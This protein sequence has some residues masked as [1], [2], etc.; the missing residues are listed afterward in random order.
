[1]FSSIEDLFLNITIGIGLI[2]GIILLFFVIKCIINI[3][4]K[5]AFEDE[6]NIKLETGFKVRENKNKYSVNRFELCYPKWTYSNK[7]GSKNKVRNNNSLI[8]YYSTLYFERF[9]LRTKSPIQMIDLVKEIRDK[10][11]DNII[12][13]SPE[14]IKKYTELKRKKDLINKA[15]VAQTIIDS[16]AEDPTDFETFCAELLR[17]MGYEAEVTQK[18]NDGGY[19]IILNKDF[20]KSI[21]ECKCYAQDHSIGRPMIQKLV[22]ANHEAKANNM[23]F[24]TT[25]KFS[26][27]A[28]LFA[29]ETDVELIDGKKLIEL[30]NKYYK[31]AS[32]I[33]VSRSEWELDYKDLQKFYPPDVEILKQ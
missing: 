4:N 12:E 3:I 33:V 1:M 9:I 28:I 21:V 32:K 5:K 27:E 31:K 18:T 19:D 20:E 29:N 14:E 13:K 6:Y 10:Y 8:F 11:K 22:G 25:S 7:N 23:K 15:D 30:I 17:K 2:V 24:I 16:F 26:K